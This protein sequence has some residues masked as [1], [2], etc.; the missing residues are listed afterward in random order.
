MQ[1]FCQTFG[2]SL[3]EINAHVNNFIEE[4]DRVVAQVNNANDI[5]DEKFKTMIEQ[6]QHLYEEQKKAKLPLKQL[7]SKSSEFKSVTN[8]GIS[9][10]EASIALFNS[11]CRSDTEKTIQIISDFNTETNSKM[12]SIEDHVVKMKN[13]DKEYKSNIDSC[14]SKVN[15]TIN[16]QKEELCQ[17][18]TKIGPEINAIQLETQ[19]MLQDNANKLVDIISREAKRISDKETHCLALHKNQETHTKDYNKNFTVGLN[20]CHEYVTNFRRCELKT[21]QPTGDTPSKREFSYPNEFVQTSPHNLI[22]K[23]FWRNHD[24]SNLDCSARLDSSI[25]DINETASFLDGIAEEKSSSILV[26]TDKVTT[27]RGE[28][29]PLAQQ[30]DNIID[31]SSGVILTQIPQVSKTFFNNKLNVPN[32]GGFNTVSNFCLF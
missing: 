22:I 3:Q 12:S 29:T 17:Q 10:A 32:S 27:L 5:N 2:S 30:I 23:R 11:T 15:T 13:I 18:L 16:T 19:V 8:K 31:N 7:P 1:Q 21:Y 25:S 20:E 6:M 9:N 26:Q 14:I 24:G 4:H 28:R